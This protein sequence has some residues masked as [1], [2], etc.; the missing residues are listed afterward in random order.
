M[1]PWSQIQVYSPITDLHFCSPCK[2][3]F[4]VYYSFAYQELYPYRCHDTTC[5]R[6]T[7]R[8]LYNSPLGSKA[9]PHLVKSKP[10]SRTIYYMFK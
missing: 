2:E 5:V 9:T 8:Y 6:L 1:G 4:Q 3:M 7:F 10:L